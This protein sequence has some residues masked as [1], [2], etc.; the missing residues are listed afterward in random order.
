MT[1]LYT[2]AQTDTAHGI[3]DTHYMVYVLCNF[4]NCRRTIVISSNTRL[5]ARFMMMIC[6]CGAPCAYRTDGESVLSVQH[7][8]RLSPD[9]GCSLYD[10]CRFV[11]AVVA[12]LLC[13]ASIFCANVLV[14]PAPACAVHCCLCGIHI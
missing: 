2:H 7:C 1:E 3:R 11:V 13:D 12:I 9:D 6:V 4:H 10:F 5:P 14:R 8:H